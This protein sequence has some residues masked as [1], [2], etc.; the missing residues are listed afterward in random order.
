MSTCLLVIDVQESFRHRPY[1]SERD[2]P[3][4]LQA[5]N[6]L[7]EGCTAR[8][9][10][11]VRI[12][13]AAESDQPQDPFTL[14]SGFVRPLQGLQPFDAA[15]IFYK[16]R[17]SALVGTGLETWLIRHGIRSVLISGI[18]TEQCCETTARH[19]SD[20]GFDVCYVPKA[21]LTF[22]MQHADGSPLPAQQI[23][24]R[25]VAVLANRFARIA[26]PDEALH[27]LAA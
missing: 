13:H 7:I 11:I 24:A 12:F 1:F 21:T 22:D 20:L 10:P 5:Q 23:K 4:Y 14:S 15:A 26:T 17:H 8:Q 18:R 27:T 3:A 25:T 9:V 6:T 2:L 16:T 19:A